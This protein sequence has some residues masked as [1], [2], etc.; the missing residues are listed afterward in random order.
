M[1]DEAAV[2]TCDHQG[3]ANKWSMQCQESPYQYF[4][5]CFKTSH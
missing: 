2:Y 3:K 4:S 1:I 5:V